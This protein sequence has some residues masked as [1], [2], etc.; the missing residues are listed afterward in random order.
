L[1]IF[2]IISVLLLLPYLILILYYWQSWLKIKEYDV[3]DQK[4]IGEGVSI[5]VIIPARNEE[6]NI[7]NCLRSIINQTYSE[8]LFEIIVIDDHSTDKTAEVVKSFRKNN[9]RVIKLA[10]ITGNSI[11]NSYKKKAVETGVGM[12]LGS[13]IVTTD[14]DC[15]APLKWL[16]TIA[17]FYNTTGTV[18]IAAPVSYF[19]ILPNDSFLK[20]F[21]KIFQSL[22]FMTLQGITGASVS[23]KIHNMCNGAN[24]AYEKK[25]FYEVNGF[26]G[27]DSIA[28][29][30]DMLLMHKIQKLYPDKIGFLKSRD[31]IVKTGAAETLANFLNQRVRWASKADK[32]PDKDHSRSFT[33]LS[34]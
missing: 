12:A 4:I 17:S 20:K 32:Y 6:K 1:T 30:D 9:I 10:D 16:Q 31:S 7:G 21:F 23:K 2:I 8:R 22:D 34:F 13:L 25:V 18:F 26:E 5:S 24:L 14:A 28:S 15:V 27:I 29:G 19:P 3:A 11:L 33:C